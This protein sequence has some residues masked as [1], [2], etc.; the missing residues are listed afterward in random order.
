MEE[1]TGMIQIFAGDF[2]P[3]GYMICAGQ[4]LSV[5]QHTALFSLIGNAY[6]GD[7]R[8]T[9]KLP[10]L[11]GRAIFGGYHNN[12]QDISGLTPKEAAEFGGVEKVALGIQHIPPHNHKCIA[13]SGNRESKDPA[14]NYLGAAGGNFYTR[15]D[16]ADTLIEMNP[17]VIA[18]TGSGEAHENMSP[19]LCLNFIICVDGNYPPRP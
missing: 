18:P 5:R 8:E 4:T 9:F 16:T 10:N 17:N 13:I 15:K 11:S 2:A 3:V 7:G 6:G 14:N 19:F 12:S 1:Y